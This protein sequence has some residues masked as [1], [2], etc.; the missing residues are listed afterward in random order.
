MSPIV[1]AISSPPGLS[2]SR[3]TIARDRSIPATGTPRAA[4]GRAIRPVPIANSSADPP[5]A[6]VAS[7]STVAEI[8]RG[9][10]LLRGA[11]V[12][13]RGDAFAEEP[14][15]M[16]GRVRHRP[17]SRMPRAGRSGRRAHG[18][19]QPVL[20]A[21]A[22]A[23][24]QGA[25]G[26]HPPGRQHAAVAVSNSSLKPFGG[27][28]KRPRT[29]RGGSAASWPLPEH[30]QNDRG[31][32]TRARASEPHLPRPPGFVSA[33]DNVRACQLCGRSIRRTSCMPTNT[34]TA[35]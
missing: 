8:V 18:R 29:R 7:R 9:G 15:V 12:V 13:R 4:S 33:A 14:V 11:L 31:S 35:R 28:R 23:R 21:A 20:D 34:A 27:S 10:E 6:N 30:A 1:T 2:R 16:G 22:G 26:R 19:D 24:S 17:E 25:G 3:A 5:S 32:S